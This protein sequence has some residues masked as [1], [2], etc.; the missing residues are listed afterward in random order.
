ATDNHEAAKALRRLTDPASTIAE[1]Y[2]PEFDYDGLRT[3]PKVI[4][5]HDFMKNPDYLRG[6]ARGAAAHGEDPKQY[7]RMHV[8]LWCASLARRLDG[9][10]VECGVWKGFLSLAIMEYLDW[11][12]LGKRFFLF[13]TFA[14]LEEKYLSDSEKTMTD[15]IEH[16]QRYYRKTN[17]EAVQANF[18][19]FQNVHFVRGSVPDT[20]A[21]VNV[22][23][24]CYLS[25]DMNNAYPEIEA[26]KFFWNKLVP[27]APILLDDYGFVSYEEQKRAF[28]RF[29][30][31]RGV[32]ILALP[33][34]QGLMI[35]P[36][37]F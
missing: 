18:A 34:G 13:D 10:F 17:F 25:L 21:E 29:A 31:E 2:T 14:G 12:S 37:R 11:N 8:A 1:I 15:K 35:K 24:V 4:H 9:D 16:L 19:P 33:T 3:D 26:A 20:L 6:Y 32:A 30:E 22:G 7:W 28:D 23:K 5:N 27:G 36:W